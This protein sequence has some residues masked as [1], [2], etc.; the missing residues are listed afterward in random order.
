[1]VISFA[2]LFKIQQNQPISLCRCYEGRKCCVVVVFFF[3]LQQVTSFYKAGQKQDSKKRNMN[4][5]FGNKE[6]NH[7]KQSII[8]CKDMCVE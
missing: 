6:N 7:F 8:M 4:S 5:H 1:M 3:S 2:V